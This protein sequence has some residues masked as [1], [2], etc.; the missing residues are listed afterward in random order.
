MEIKFR[1]LGKLDKKIYNVDMIDFEK[2]E[3]RLSQI[4]T[5]TNFSEKYE[6]LQYTNIDDIN[7]E[8]IY[9]GDIVYIGNSNEEYEIVFIDGKFMILDIQKHMF[10]D[11]NC[12]FFYRLDYLDLKK[13]KFIK[14]IRNKYEL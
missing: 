12:N 9:Y 11:S 5:I 14:R 13:T 3:I 7:G 10:W 6:L 1:A 2:D 4:G 8:E